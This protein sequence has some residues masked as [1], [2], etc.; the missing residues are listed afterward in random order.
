MSIILK[1]MF[2]TLPTQNHITTI[3]YSLLTATVNVMW[4]WLQELHAQW[5]S[6]RSTCHGVSLVQ[7]ILPVLP[8]YFDVI[9]S[10]IMLCS[11]PT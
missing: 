8:V 4:P 6:T 2:T 7:V 10:Q 11:K 9:R 1:I 3:I 5:G